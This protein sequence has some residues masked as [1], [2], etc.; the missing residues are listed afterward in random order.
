M[1]ITFTEAVG[2]PVPA[3]EGEIHLRGSGALPDGDSFRDIYILAEGSGGTATANLPYQCFSASDAQTY[4]G[5]ASNGHC[6]AEY[7]FNSLEATVG[8]FKGKVFAVNLVEL[9]GGTKGTTTLTFAVNASGPGYWEFNILGHHVNF[10]VATA[11]TPTVQGAAM[12]AAWEALSWKDKPPVGLI[13]VA[14]VVTLLATNKCASLLKA[15]SLTTV[16]DPG[17]ATTATWLAATL[18]GA[19]GVPA[20]IATALANLVPVRTPVIIASW[21][22][23]ASNELVVDHIN[24]KAN[25]TSMLPATFITALDES[26]ANLVTAA[27]LLDDDDGQ[28]VAFVGVK[29]SK[30]WDCETAAKFAAVNGAEPHL[31]RS[32][33][34]LVVDIDPPSLSDTFSAAQCKTLLQGGVTPL[35]VPTNDD[36]VRIVRAVSIRT[37]Y[38]VM[39]FC[40]MTVADY[41]R[42]SI[43][44]RLQAK[45]NRCNIIADDAEPP[46]VDFIV[47]PSSIKGETFACCKELEL[48]GYLTNVSTDW[49]S[50]AGTLVGSTYS[51]QFPITEPSQLH[52]IQFRLDVTI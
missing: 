17:V 25:A 38:G 49:L 21:T 22:D 52:N 35:V 41:V 46:M 5:V 8:K 13:S 47:T 43:V 40:T 23:A 42:A 51:M 27:D 29:G 48:A 14:G 30:T 7:V 11:D 24:A 20:A 44:T 18:T 1:T 32:L 36:Q 12:Q 34:G 50:F 19:A 26:A 3:I 2:G 37:D 9:V 45:F 6:L 15:A 16:H 28:R 31:A 10:S 4:F 39:D 33:N